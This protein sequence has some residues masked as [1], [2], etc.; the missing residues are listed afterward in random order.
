MKKAKT[1][2]KPKGA[3][4]AKRGGRK[5]VSTK[6]QTKKARPAKVRRTK[7]ATAKR[8]TSQSTRAFRF[9]AA[10]VVSIRFKG[11]AKPERFRVDDMVEATIATQDGQTKSY[12][13]YRLVSNDKQNSDGSD[14]HFW[15]LDPKPVGAVDS[16]GP[17]LWQPAGHQSTD[18]Y[19]LV[20]SCSGNYSTK[21]VTSYD[22]YGS[23][24][25]VKLNDAPTYR[26]RLELN[27]KHEFCESLTVTIRTGD[28]LSVG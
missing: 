2:T 11:E 25:T 23:L 1:N 20:K 7:P 28:V 10:D 17:S 16:I 22:G 3:S 19:D 6:G 18:G 21:S 27:G 13:Q 26:M 15:F 9:T 24:H 5:I 12:Y 14:R 8:A 4:T